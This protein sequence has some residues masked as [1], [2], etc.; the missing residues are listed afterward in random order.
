VAAHQCYWDNFHFHQFSLSLHWPVTLNCLTC[1]IFV[2]SVWIST[3]GRT[4]FNALE[5]NFPTSLH[6]VSTLFFF[7]LKCILILVPDY[8]RCLGFL[9]FL[10]PCLIGLAPRDNNLINME[11]RSIAWLIA[12]SQPKCCHLRSLPPFNK[13]KI[14]FCQKVNW[15]QAQVYFHLKTSFYWKVLLIHFVC[16]F[17]EIGLKNK[18]SW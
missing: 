1:L 10:S 17:L 15:D 11:Q 18:F 12:R 8:T 3:M 14:S 4:A 9:I 6:Y 13:V 2:N 16:R 5:K 7:L